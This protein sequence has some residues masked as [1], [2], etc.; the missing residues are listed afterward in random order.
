MSEQKRRA[1]IYVFSGTGNTFIAA[2]KTAAALFQRGILTDIYRICTQDS[3]LYPLA[4]NRMNAD[5]TLTAAS[6]KPDTEA[7]SAET[8]SASADDKAQSSNL[9]QLSAEFGEVPDPNGYDIAGFA[10]P[11]H[12]FNS[13]QLFLR[14]VKHLP[15]LNPDKTGMTG[16][17]FKTS[18]EPFKPNSSSSITLAYFLKKK[19]FI[20][21]I[22]LH[23]LMPYNIMFRY[24]NAMAKQ[25]YLHTE[26]LSEELADKVICISDDLSGRNR[27][28]KDVLNNIRK[29]YRL[30]FNILITLMAYIF[31]IQW[32]AANANGLLYKVKAAKCTGC[33]ICMKNCPSGNIKMVVPDEAL[34]SAVTTLDEAE[35][36]TVRRIPKVGSHCTM[37]ME[38]TMWCPNG[39]INPGVLTPWKVNPKWDFEKILSDDA[40]PSNWTDDP[41]AGYFKLFRKYFEKEKAADAAKPVTITIPE[42]ITDLGDRKLEEN[43]ELFKGEDL[44]ES[45]DI[46]VD[47]DSEDEFSTRRHV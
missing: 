14:F 1:I 18:G 25:M 24:P 12:A 32:P 31:R 19:G 43:M 39:A 23:M 46:Q 10:Y 6:R 16:F 2:Q 3:S 11:I 36:T 29:K 20:P 26:K 17:I 21:C 28:S 30:H 33:G 8:G 47:L 41:N 15:K 13:P 9:V 7:L 38:C 37:C 40:I 5:G 27:F 35:R 22:D 44:I 42:N 45:L 34:Y 4:F